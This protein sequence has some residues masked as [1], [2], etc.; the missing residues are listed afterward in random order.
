ML[1]SAHHEYSIGGSRLIP[2]RMH[3]SLPG[4]QKTSDRRFRWSEA[5]WWAWEE[6]NL[7]LHPYQLLRGRP[8]RVT[9]QAS[10]VHKRKIGITLF[11]CPRDKCR[12]LLC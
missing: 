5:V 7:R 11:D 2:D 9:F 8:K 10:E 3:P 12:E 6:L 1:P 4:P